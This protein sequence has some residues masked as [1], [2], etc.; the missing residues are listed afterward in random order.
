MYSQRLNEPDRQ[1]SARGTKPARF[2]RTS[3]SY[4]A[5]SLAGICSLETNPDIVSLSQKG[6]LIPTRNQWSP[7]KSRGDLCLNYL[8]EVFFYSPG[9]PRS[10][11][12]GFAI[13]IN[14]GALKGL[15]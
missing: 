14:A 8:E 3:W 1:S 5:D 10:G 7:P 4:H 11:Y 15:A 13:R 12:P 2:V 9:L 6:N